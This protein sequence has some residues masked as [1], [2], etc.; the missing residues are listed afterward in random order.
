MLRAL[1][2]TAWGRPVPAPNG[3]RLTQSGLVSEPDPVTL[4][5]GGVAWVRP[6]FAIRAAA[7]V[8]EKCTLTPDSN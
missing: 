6:G 7:T 1:R 5:Y 2:L 8:V 3:V 4:A